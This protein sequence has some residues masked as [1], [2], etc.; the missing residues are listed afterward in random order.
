MS[1]FKKILLRIHKCHFISCTIM[2]SFAEFES[3]KKWLI[4][5]LPTCRS[6]T[7]AKANK[8][9]DVQS[10]KD[11]MFEVAWISE[12]ADI[13]LTV[14]FLRFVSIKSIFSSSKANSLVSFVEI[15]LVM[16]GRQ[17]VRLDDSDDSHAVHVGLKY[18][19]N[20]E[21]LIW[22]ELR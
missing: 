15:L 8:G 14:S 10:T 9:V 7:S 17:E 1:S 13:Q 11:Q 4:L 18:S 20:R 16:D 3:L 22:N 19:I 12:M 21:Q 5:T 6:S 2:Y